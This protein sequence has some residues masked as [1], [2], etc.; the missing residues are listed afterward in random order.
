MRLKAIW[1]L[2][3]MTFKVKTLLRQSLPLRTLP[4][5]DVDCVFARRVILGRAGIGEAFP[6]IAS[7]KRMCAV[8]R[9]DKRRKTADRFDRGRRCFV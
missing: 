8:D 4:E 6:T 1:T 7:A 5:I 2:F 3:G 9:I